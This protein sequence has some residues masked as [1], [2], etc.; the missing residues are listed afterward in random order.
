MMKKFVVYTLLLTMV[1]VSASARNRWS[2][3]EDNYHFGY[4]SA[5]L[6]YTSLSYRAGNISAKGGLGYSA[7]FGYEFRRH[8]LWISSGLQFQALGSELTIDEYTYSPPVGGMDV[9]GRTVSQ[10]IYTV[11]QRDKQSWMTLDIPIMVGF[12]S[13]GFYLGGGF[14]VAF[15]VYSAGTV[16]GSYDIDAVYD[17]YVGTV[18]DMHYYT[19]YPYEGK[20]DA[21]KLRPMVALAGEIGYDFLSLMPTN[22]VI[23]HMLKLGLAFEYG[24]RSVKTAPL[25]EPLTINPDNITDV[26]INPYFATERGTN[27]WTVPYFV[28]VKLTYMVGGSRSTTATWH[29]GCQCYGYK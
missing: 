23:C 19:N 18:S 12:Y 28:G 9:M 4:V 25:S 29:R 27:S 15:P 10:Y 21:Y 2:L 1:A 11:Q 6:G 17:R 3:D 13:N 26:T 24:L 8:H 16:S 7:G 22:E 20:A 14:K 5:G